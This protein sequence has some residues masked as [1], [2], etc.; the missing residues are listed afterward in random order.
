MT[1]KVQ[2]SDKSPI[3]AG[4]FGHGIEGYWYKNEKWVLA[5]GKNY[6]YNEAPTAVKTAIQRAFM[7]DRKSLAYL[8]KMGLKKANEIFDRW[9]QCVIGGLDSMPDILNETL[10]PDS[11]NNMCS[12]SKCPHRGKL[13]SRALG[14]RNYEVETIATLQAGES[15]ENAASRLCVSYTGLKSRVEKIKDKLHVRN[16][17]ELMAVSGHIGI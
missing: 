16:M 12:D 8:A 11:F 15:I 4:I 17:A 5:H 3:P 7:N 13:C 1:A 9:Y 10:T 2:F 6:R 14:L